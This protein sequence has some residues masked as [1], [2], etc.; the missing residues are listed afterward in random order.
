MGPALG[1]VWIVLLFAAAGLVLRALARREERLASIP[2]DPGPDFPLEP[3]AVTADGQ[4]FLLQEDGVRILPAGDLRSLWPVRGRYGLDWNNIV[5]QRV[6]AVDPRTHAPQASWIPGSRL[7][8]GDLIGARLVISEDPHQ[9]AWRVEALGRDRDYRVWE[10]AGEHDARVALGM[11]SRRVVRRIPHDAGTWPPSGQDYVR[12]LEQRNET[13]R[14]LRDP[15]P[16]W[17]WSA[18]PLGRWFTR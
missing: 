4:R 15:E 13:E 12:A 7:V 2:P 10:F 3:L 1:T 18:S 5:F 8:A 14:Q 11:L 16:D 9:P 17:T 6:A